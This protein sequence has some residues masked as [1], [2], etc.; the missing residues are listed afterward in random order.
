MTRVAHLA[1][2]V[3]PDGS[4]SAACFDPPRA[5]DMRPTSA[6]TWVLRSEAVTCPKCLALIDARKRVTP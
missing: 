4:M 6:E 3:A 1:A 5:I 2:K